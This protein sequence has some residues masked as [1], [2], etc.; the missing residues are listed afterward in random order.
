M[1]ESQDARAPK[2]PKA[3]TA[4]QRNENQSMDFS[5]RQRAPMVVAA[6]TDDFRTCAQ[7]LV[8]VGDTVLEVGCADGIT[9]NLISKFA[10]D[11]VGVDIAPVVIGKARSRYPSIDFRVLD[12]SNT[13]ELRRLRK[14]FSVVFV[15][16]AGLI[17]LESLLPMLDALDDALRPRLLVVKSRA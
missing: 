3:P 10:N 14:H 2:E 13:P 8:Q 15:D 17:A 12:A 11:V 16:I 9:T 6:T 5:N 1:D 4:P 7:Q